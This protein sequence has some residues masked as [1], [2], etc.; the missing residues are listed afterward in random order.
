MLNKI[1]SYW[2][3][4]KTEYE[5]RYN[6]PFLSDFETSKEYLERMK[7]YLLEKHSGANRALMASASSFSL[8]SGT[9]TGNRPRIHGHAVS[10]A[11]RPDFTTQ[12]LQTHSSL[13]VIERHGHCHWRVHGHFR[14]LLPEV[15]GRFPDVRHGIDMRKR[16]ATSG[17]VDFERLF[18]AVRGVGRAQHVIQSPLLHGFGLRAVFLT[19]DRRGY[20]KTARVFFN[21]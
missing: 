21:G 4:L 13:C 7:S 17:L 12:C 16:S 10:R 8:S 11:G 20:I 18:H 9:W 3:K 1:K 2:H 6:K 15:Q 14:A 5:K 19:Y